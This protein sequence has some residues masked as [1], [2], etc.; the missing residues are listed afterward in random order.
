MSSFASSVR[1]VQNW[2]WVNTTSFVYARGY[3]S[4][5]TGMITKIASNVCGVP[6]TDFQGFENIFGKSPKP[7]KISN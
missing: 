6:H 4:Y 3:T 5:G 2:Y 7:S 1:G